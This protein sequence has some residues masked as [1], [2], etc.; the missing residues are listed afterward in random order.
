MR[1]KQTLFVRQSSLSWLDVG[2]CHW[3]VFQHPVP[4]PGSRGAQQCQ[5]DRHRS[6]PQLH[7]RR[8]LQL[9]RGPCHVL[10]DGRQQW[11]IVCLLLLVERLLQ[12]RGLTLNWE[13]CQGRLRSGPVWGEERG[14]VWAV[15]ISAQ[16]G[17]RPA[18]TTVW[19]A[20]TSGHG[21]DLSADTTTAVRTGSFDEM[22]C[23]TPRKRCPVLFGDWK[24]SNC[25]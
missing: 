15:Q 1:W 12:A 18:R 13:Y 11:H 20:P 14:L 9:Y 19:L 21:Q 22:S 5:H 16:R 8:G 4:W 24:F 3:E 2:L 7:Q 6:S 10:K 23:F 25:Q 17:Q